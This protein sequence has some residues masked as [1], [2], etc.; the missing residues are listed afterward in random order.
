MAMVQTRQALVEQA[1]TRTLGS[2]RQ[3]LLETGTEPPVT[4]TPTGQA[5]ANRQVPA[6]TA[7]SPPPPPV[8]PVAEVPPSPPMQPEP[9]P[10]PQAENPAST[11]PTQRSPLE[12]N[13]RR[14]AEFFNGEVIDAEGT[15][16]LDV[17]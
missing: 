16:D 15:K 13:A 11:T 10:L 3:L 14:L 9:E 2:S 7:P 8:A 5:P 6:P 4:R 12:E 17:A 1:I